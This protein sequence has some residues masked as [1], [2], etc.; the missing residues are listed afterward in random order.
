MNLYMQVLTSKVLCNP[1]VYRFHLHPHYQQIEHLIRRILY[2]LPHDL[3]N[4]RK[5]CIVANRIWHNDPKNHHLHRIANRDNSP[6]IQCH[7]SVLDP[8]QRVIHL[9][10][11]HLSELFQW[12]LNCDRS[13]DQSQYV[14]STFDCSYFVLHSL[15]SH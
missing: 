1:I 12:L 11:H 15:M 8:K 5:H 7:Y 14:I 3:R 13:V 2:I 9:P 6:S 4:L 10:P